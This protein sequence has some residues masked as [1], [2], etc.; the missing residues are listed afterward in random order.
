[1]SI[2]AALRR[3]IERAGYHVTHR[4][5]LPFGV[6]PIWD[7]QRLA[8]RHNASVGTI[9]DIGAHS[10]ETATRFLEAFPAAHV[11]SFEPHPN[12][13]ACI[14]EIESDRLHPHKLALSDRCGEAEFFVFS[15]V[16]DP[17]RA[18]PASMNNSLVQNRQFS[19]VEGSYSKSIRVECVTV[20]EFCA[21]ND[22]NTLELLK[23]DTEGH[24]V[25]VLDGARQTLAE[26]G[27]RF[28]FLEYETVLPIP[29][30]V[31]GALAPAAERL[32]PL[33]F[34]L[35]ASYPNNM[36]DQPLYASFNA[37]FLS[38]ECK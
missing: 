9:F 29:T 32:E 28:V 36:V 2:K 37:L 34:R 23:I 22:V 33:G 24:E 30:A 14:A 35:V 7:I 13:F 8:V 17:S 18:M 15:D 20:D 10:G 3:G 1:M 31:G 27:V 26:R 38:P 5:V 11:Y 16:V 6:D 12:S 19:L 25:A 4:S 21:A